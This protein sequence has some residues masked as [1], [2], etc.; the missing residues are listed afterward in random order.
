MTAR[1]QYGE[2]MSECTCDP[3]EPDFVPAWMHHTGCDLFRRWQGWPPL[4]ALLGDVVDDG[5]QFTRYESADR[6][7]GF[8]PH[9]RRYRVTRYVDGTVDVLAEQETT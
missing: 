1:H 4:S 2:A 9:T 6:V 3:A 5:L 8:F 7:Q